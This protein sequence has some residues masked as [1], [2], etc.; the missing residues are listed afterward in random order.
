VSGPNLASAS[1]SEPVHRTRL[2]VCLSQSHSGQVGV[3][4]GRLDV[5]MAQYSLQTE[6]IASV[7]DVV[8]REGVPE[9][10]RADAAG[11]E[12]RSAPRCASSWLPRHHA[13]PAEV[14]ALLWRHTMK[15]KH[16]RQDVE[17]DQ[18]EVV[19]SDEPWCEYSLADGSKI[20]VRHVLGAMFRAQHSFTEDEDPLYITRSQI[21]V[22]PAEIPDDLRRKE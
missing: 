21:V 8:R 14:Y 17:V 13:S 20:R 16:G 4:H 9:T 15:I 12:R 11:C 19:K 10:V 6:G 1:V 5:G 18:I 22:I 7:H 3:D 2:P